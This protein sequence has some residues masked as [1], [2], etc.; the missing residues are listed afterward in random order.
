MVKLHRLGLAYR[1]AKVDLFYTGSPPL[2]KIA[3]YEDRLVENLESLQQRLN[4]SDD[5]WL[6]D[7]SFLGSW[8][9]APTAIDGWEEERKSLAAD[10]LLASPQD[11]WEKAC[12][13]AR[14]DKPMCA[15]FRLMS[16]CSMDFHVLSALW[17]LEVGHLLDAALGENAYG[18]RLRRK[19]ATSKECTPG[20]NEFAVGSFK[21]Y[22]GPFRQWRDN[23]IKA[24]RS[25]LSDGKSIVALTADVS[26]F[27]HKLNPTFLLDKA[28][29]KGMLG[30]VLN[31]AQ[32]RLHKRFVK[33]LDAWQKRTPLKTGLPVGLPASSLVA[34]LALI[35]FDQFI[36]REVIP[37]YYGRYVDDILLV[38]DNGP[39][40]S[41][42]LE[43][44][45]WL[46]ERSGEALKVLEA[47]GENGDKSVQFA[48]DY[49]NDR[50]EIVFKNSKNKTFL[51]SGDAGL[52]LV[53]SI[54]RQIK[55]R[56]SEWRALPDIPDSSDQVATDLISATDRDGQAAD[57]LRKAD[58][59]TMRRAGFAIKLRDYEAHER[60]LEPSEWRDV[61]HAFLKACT[62]NVL[63]P[64]RFFELAIYL[65]RLIRLAT[66]CSDFEQ[67][68]LMVTTLNNLVESVAKNCT[69]R[70]KSESSTTQDTGD[71]VR[72]WRSQL[73]SD[74][75][76]GIEAAF[77]TKLT[78]ESAER[79][80]LIAPK[81]AALLDDEGE[82]A[83]KR[84]LI[85]QSL[86]SKHAKLFSYDLGHRPFRFSYLPTG[87][88]PERGVPDSGWIRCQ[89]AFRLLPENLVSGSKELVRQI[90]G[91]V[92][93]G[94]Y[95]GIL[96]ATRPI[97]LHETYAL[98]NREAYS[99]E[100]QKRV[101]E[102][103]LSARG[104][105][106][107]LEIPRETANGLH[108]PD[109]SASGKFPIAV[110]SW[111]TKY[112]SWTASVTRT[113]EPD[114]TRYGRLNCLINDFLSG[115]NRPR[116]RY[117]IMPELAIPAH[118]FTPIAIKLQ[119]VGVSLIAGVE[120]I[121]TEHS[122]VRNQVWASLRYD[123]LGFPSHITY[124]QDKQKPAIHEERELFNVAGLRLESE[125]T[126]PDGQPPV[127]KHGDHYFGILICSELTNINHRAAFR[128]KIDTLIVPEW[129]KDTETFNSLVE[130]AALDVHA[131]IIQCN[132]R[133][134]GDSRI[135]APYKENWKRD[136]LRVKGGDH[137]YI[138]TGTIDV[139]AL[140]S[141]Q[142]SHR[143]PG[144]PFKPVP[145]GF[146]LDRGRV[147]L[148]GGEEV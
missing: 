127:L 148:P 52:L 49:L 18:N 57:N 47:K 41:T 39:R 119:R 108:V 146:E 84:R 100:G 11:E 78:Q 42:Q 35:G 30:V 142:S 141:F 83:A 96:F 89:Q 76:E 120:Y 77:P 31:P 106:I 50:S 13:E 101:Q 20:V 73:H 37:I 133:K 132:D 6:T 125:D 1:K 94:V 90:K 71:R 86:R 16:D 14:E 21:Q 117:L 48:P 69:I 8:T 131:Y 19:K 46:E 60:D 53:D 44:W 139:H 64:P 34:N 70:L 7:E 74:I 102:I 121:H 93:E 10:L 28:F 29:L 72:R 105:S 138:V 137:D 85:L 5:N 82:G 51:M 24:M 144:G 122:V 4:S 38:L 59:M 111:K 136:I 9:L 112:P 104:F 81:I 43:V 26:S 3:N 130:S 115:A 97:N 87:L 2:T 145:E 63:V 27:Y 68:K 91:N 25:A 40:F 36:E 116:P 147:M 88:T 79:W 66:A 15:E 17:M 65:P 107:K 109:S 22:F 114:A 62:D 12:V 58:A 32:R 113:V 56:A 95:S 99:K 92:T 98:M 134:Y 67:L 128:G 75:L 80:A 140:R 33:A 143:S 23:G 61:R 55:E 124:R 110:T 103:V 118:W 135:R 45:K 54:E 123:G 129:N 126:W